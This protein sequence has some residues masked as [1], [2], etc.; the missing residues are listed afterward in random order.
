[1]QMAIRLSK[2]KF[3]EFLLQCISL[4]SPEGITTTFGTV[5]LILIFLNPQHVSFPDFCI[6]NK[7]FGRCP[8]CGTTRALACF[9]K[10]EFS[11]SIKYNSNVILVAPSVIA[12]FLKNLAKVAFRHKTGLSAWTSQ[13][14]EIVVGNQRRETRL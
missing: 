1:M 6:V 13:V 4:S 11:E 5:I 2:N 8:A 14:R 10:G 7:M 12:V 3:I 9:L